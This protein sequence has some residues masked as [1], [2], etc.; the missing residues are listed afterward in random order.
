MKVRRKEDGTIAKSNVADR[1]T[2]ISSKPQQETARLP[3]AYIA[4]MSIG[5]LE[6][7]ISEIIFSVPQKKEVQ[8]SL[9]E[10]VSDIA[11][12]QRTNL[13]VLM[14]C[15]AR[16]GEPEIEGLTAAQ[17]GPTQKRA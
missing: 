8:N 4:R 17:I 7:L 14:N 5:L 16:N 13:E 3:N 15:R 12:D 2:V 6:G 1:S 10:L 11:P 9:H